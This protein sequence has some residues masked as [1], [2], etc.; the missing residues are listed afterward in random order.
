MYSLRHETSEL[1][2]AGSAPGMQSM[3]KDQGYE[4]VDDLTAVDMQTQISSQSGNLK[5]LME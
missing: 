4:P 3:P 2:E 5:F 1:S